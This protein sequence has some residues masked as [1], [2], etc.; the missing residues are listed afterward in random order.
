MAK[1]TKPDNNSAAL[2][3]RNNKD[4]LAQIDK[5]VEDCQLSKLVDMGTMEQTLVLADGMHQLRQLLTDDVMKAVSALQGTRLGFNTDRKDHAS[6][7]PIP[8][9]RDCFIEATIRGLRAVGNEWNILAGNCYVTLEGL[10]RLVN[11]ATGGT[12]A[13]IIGLPHTQLD[14]EGRGSALIE[15]HATWEIDGKKD[16]QHCDPAKEDGKTEAE[17]MDTRIPVKVNKGM[18]IDALLGKA[19]R[20]LLSLDWGQNTKSPVPEGDP[21]PDD[22]IDMTPTAAEATQET[23]KPKDSLFEGLPED[24]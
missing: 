12:Y 20:K 7:Y 10:T 24:Q 14:R 15:A 17:K 4:A 13:P 22:Y 2:A 6:G 5:V 21:D 3:L 23:N 9:V 18:G 1:Q 8:V 11:E 19:K 16:S